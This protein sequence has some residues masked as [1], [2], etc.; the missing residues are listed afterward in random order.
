M[1][2]F[3][4]SDCRQVLYL[5]ERFQQ[6]ASRHQCKCGDIF[7]AAL[8]QGSRPQHAVPLESERN[9]P[10][11]PVNVKSRMRHCRRLVL[12]KFLFFNRTLKPYVVTADLLSQAQNITKR[13]AIKVVRVCHCFY[14]FCYEVGG[15]TNFITWEFYSV[16][17]AAVVYILR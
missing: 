14:R 17:L 16:A 13:N 1:T 10:L 2:E 4:W 11:D 9:L 6:F 3:H 5:K 8:R 12:L 15:H 7:Y